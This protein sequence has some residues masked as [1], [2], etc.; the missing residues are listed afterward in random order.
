MSYRCLF[1]CIVFSYLYQEL[2]EKVREL[3]SA[4]AVRTESDADRVKTLKNVWAAM[5]SRLSFR[6]SLGKL[7]YDFHR[8]RK[9]VR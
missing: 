1:Y 3:T 9:S 4:S 2:H 7:Y 5:N 8:H 6:L